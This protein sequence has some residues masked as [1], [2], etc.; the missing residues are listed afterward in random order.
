MRKLVELIWNSGISIKETLFL[1]YR[2][3]C[4]DM[5]EGEQARSVTKRSKY[6]SGAGLKTMNIKT[7]E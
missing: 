7:L 3:M 5:Y 6:G 4:S 1:F 2:R